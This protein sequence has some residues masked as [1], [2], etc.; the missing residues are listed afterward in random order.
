MPKRLLS[1]SCPYAKV[2]N[3]NDWLLDGRT[4]LSKVTTNYAYHILSTDMVD[5][6]ED[7]QCA[8]S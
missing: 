2:I 6:Q 5:G 3:Q 7:G 8:S 4:C 1:S